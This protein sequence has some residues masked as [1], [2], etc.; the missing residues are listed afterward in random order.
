[1]YIGRKG[2]GQWLAYVER[3]WSVGGLGT[4]IS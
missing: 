1:M 4:L 3:D 2:D